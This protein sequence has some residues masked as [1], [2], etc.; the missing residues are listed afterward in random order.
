M[1][2]WIKVEE[3]PPTGNCLVKLESE[4]CHNRVHSAFFGE[5]FQIIATVFAWDA[6]KVLE[7]MPLEL[8]ELE[9]F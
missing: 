6:P 8:V 3:R 7:W 4:L 9:D 2:K 5:D 1:S